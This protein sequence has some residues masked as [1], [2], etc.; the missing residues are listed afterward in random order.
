MNSLIHE[1]R[2]K[3]IEKKG[4]KYFIIPEFEETHLVNHGFTTRIGGLSKSPFNSLNLGLKTDDNRENVIENFKIICDVFENTIDRAVLSDQVHKTD[5][6]IV[7]NKD[8]GKGLVKNK[9]YKD[10]DGLVT[11]EPDVMLFTFFADCVP[12][13]FLDK[14]KK[15]VGLA[16]GGWRGTVDKI[17]GKMIDIMKKNYSSDP[18]DILVGI[19]P[20]IGQCCYEVGA[21]VYKRFNTNFTSVSN[22]LKPTGEGKWKLNLWEANKVVLEESGVPCRNIIISEVCT[23]CNSD[24]FFSYRKENGITGRMAA[25]IQL[26]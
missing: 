13:F 4:V 24:I 16:H 23:S 17:S 5:I 2:F 11:N 8:I 20:S 18:N 10:I 3:L 22:V 9:D 26:K 7:T 6:K 14:V 21:D 19:G 25:I 12:I 1:E 15:V